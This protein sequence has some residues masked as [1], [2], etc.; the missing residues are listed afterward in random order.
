[1]TDDLQDE[2]ERIMRDRYFYALRARLENWV[3]I[4]LRCR[5]L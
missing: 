2:M 1:M 3:T 5:L 4:N